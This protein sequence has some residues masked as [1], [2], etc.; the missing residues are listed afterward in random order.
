MKNK[1]ARPNLRV[2]FASLLIGAGLT[3]LLVAYGPV[4]V[5][6]LGFVF[7]QRNPQLID[8]DGQSNAQSTEIK[9]VDEDFGI[10][11]P[12]I[13]VNAAIVQDVD[14]YSS[15]EY[16]RQLAKGVAHAAGTALPDEERSMFLFAHAS[17]DILMARRYNSVFYLLNKLEAGDQLLIYYR[18]APYHYQVISSKEVAADAVSYLENNDESDLIL[19]T[20]TPPGTTW[21][22]LLVFADKISPDL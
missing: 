2:V 14:P 15:F 5:A 19:M 11:I 12:K 21:R 9:A 16:Q 17:G 1:K 6:E 22:R 8:N 18:G 7:S 4:L 10:V 3:V 20:C 13:N